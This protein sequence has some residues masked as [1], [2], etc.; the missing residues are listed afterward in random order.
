M[1]MALSVSKADRIVGQHPTCFGLT[2]MV[3]PSIRCISQKTQPSNCFPVIDSRS[4]S[5][6][7]TVCV[8]QILGFHH[9]KQSLAQFRGLLR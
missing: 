8:A 9:L 3:S 6:S 1:V 4:I 2:E 5:I 7:H